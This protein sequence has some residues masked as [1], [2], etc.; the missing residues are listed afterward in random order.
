MA[1]ERNKKTIICILLS[2]ISAAL[3]AVAAGENRAGQ[4]GTAFTYQGQLKRDGVPVNDTLCDFE[5]TLWD[6]PTAEDADVHRIGVAQVEA[7]EPVNGLFTVE[8]N[9]A[10]QFGDGLVAGEARWLQ[11][12]V[13]CPQGSPFQS[14]GR[15]RL[16]PA[17]MAM[18]L[19]V[20]RTNGAWNVIGGYGG[21][22]ADIGGSLEV[23]LGNSVAPDAWCA[24]IAGGG[25]FSDPRGSAPGRNRVTEAFGTVGGGVG[26]VAG[27]EDDDS[28]EYA[29]TVAGGLSNEAAGPGATV[30]GGWDNTA[31]GDF[32]GVG[33]GN[34]NRATG[35]FSVVEGGS[36]NYAT[37]R[38][39]TIAGGVS[40]HAGGDYSF[41]AGRRA[42]VRNPEASGDADGDEGT[43]VWADATN[44]DFQSTGPNQFLIRA[45]GGVGIGTNDPAGY[46]LNVNGSVNAG[47]VLVNGTPVG[48]AGD[49]HSLDAADGNPVDAV[50][51]DNDGNV[52]IGTTEPQRLLDI[53]GSF[54]TVR[55]TNTDNGVR[56]ELSALGTIPGVVSLRSA[57]GHPLSLG[58]DNT[59]RMEITADGR[60]GIATSSPLTELDVR[61]ASDSNPAQILAANKNQ[62]TWLE[63]WSG[64]SAGANAPAIIWAE[65]ADLRLGPGDEDGDPFQ[66]SMR[67]LADGR[68]G[69]GTRDPLKTLQVG[70]ETVAGSEGMIR[71]E[72]KSETGSNDFYAWEMGVPQT[73]DDTTGVGYSFVIDDPRR[74]DP[75]FMI[76]WNNG[77]VGMGTS[78][79]QANLHVKGN[80]KVLALEGTNH[81]YIEWYPD[82]FAD[83][84]KGWM[85]WGSSGTSTFTIANQMLGDIAFET[86]NSNQLMVLRPTGRIDI[87]GIDPK[88]AVG[89]TSS[90]GG[91]MLAVN[92][93]A[94]KPGG[95][96]WSVLS[97]RRL[98]RN[99]HRLS[100][101][102]TRLLKLRG[103]EFEYKDPQ[104]PL[105]LP[106]VQV[107]LVAQEVERVFPEWVSDD[108]DG[109]KY[110][111]VRGFVALTV[112]ALRELRSERNE[113]LRSLEARIT[114]LEKTCQALSKTLLEHQNRHDVE[115]GRIQQRLAAVEHG[116]PPTRQTLSLISPTHFGFAVLA[117]ILVAV[118]HFA[119]AIP[120]LYRRS[121]SMNKGARLR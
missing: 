89:I 98:K 20:L 66:E 106:G 14:L 53:S 30:S 114:E 2:G 121:S 105:S 42:K 44:A 46:A 3:P 62:D 23:D 96:E 18:A 31:S 109:F 15:Q 94:A 92:G 71:L 100:G 95:G 90:I 43:F 48:G 9:G 1:R 33:G 65:G 64:S 110:V 75:E 37:A 107:G 74:A 34:S 116:D 69:I 45:S 50:Y 84:R 73:R 81:A 99:V 93:P 40:N 39:A 32:S 4:M 78:E 83:G 118:W 22:R 29:P 68:V 120:V 63:L 113:Q 77:N 102:L 72:S 91:L 117:I 82:G 54:A 26:N 16:A 36:A 87:S 35:P 70:D 111:T 47:A 5:F 55:F 21:H 25:F 57:T 80:E 85:G 88:L 58:T 60:I 6:D 101:A 28:E 59:G 119:K 13:S 10:G 104:A 108:D 86:A 17:P 51:V 41:A 79:P 56:G 7:K 103:V 24:T 12:R 38:F 76:K 8:L 27:D 52:G 112:E 61:S 115:L 11:S 67:I 49:G 97:D 19:P